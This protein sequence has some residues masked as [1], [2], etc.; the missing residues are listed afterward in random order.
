MDESSKRKVGRTHIEE[1]RISVL[2]RNVQE[3]ILCF[4]PIRDAVRTS[5]LARNWRNCW[6]TIPNLVFDED[7]LS[8]KSCYIGRSRGLE[9]AALNFVSVISNVLL[10]HNGPILRFSLCFPGFCDAKIILDCFGQWIP[11][12]SS[13]GIKQLYLKGL[14]N[15]WFPSTPAFGGL[16]F[17]KEIVLTDVST[18]EQNVFNCPVLERL[19]LF[20]CKGLLPINFRAPN[21]KYLRQLYTKMPS[22]YSLAGLENLIEFSCMV[23]YDMEMPSETS[24]VVKVFGCLNKIE[25]ITISTSFIEYLAAGG[26]PNKF[27][28]PLH[29]LKTLTF[30]DI[31]LT[32]VSEVSCLLCMIRSAPNLS[33]LHILVDW[34]GKDAGEGNLNNYWVNVSEDCTIDQL[35]IVTFCHLKGQRT[36][37]DLIKYLLAHSP[38]LKTMYINYVASVLKKDAAA[39]MTKE[40]LQ[41][42]KTSSGAQIIHLKQIPFELYY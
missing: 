36:E 6:S 38:Q 12:F 39:A 26:S 25:K 9:L 32:R 11:L 29:Y 15:V 4:M 34:L 23:A 18:S 7:I 1:D 40:M 22:E 8:E 27:P 3:T 20:R 28:H 2:P 21:L 42:C 33:K 19:N 13:K 35:E 24:N 17:L 37:L 30:T 41:Y 16:T 10:L 5:I 31:H 14:K